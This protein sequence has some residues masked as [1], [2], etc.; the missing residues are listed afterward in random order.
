MVPRVQ[1]V[2][3]WSDLLSKLGR[4]EYSKI[5]TKKKIGFGGFGGGVSQRTIKNGGAAVDD[6]SRCRLLEVE[7][8]MAQ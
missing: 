2:L 1:R 7:V 8:D 4:I 3:N 5:S 6:R